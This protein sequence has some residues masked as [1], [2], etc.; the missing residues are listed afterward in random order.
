MAGK[1][2]PKPKKVDPATYARFKRE[3]R[4]FDMDHDRRIEDLAGGLE[5]KIKLIATLEEAL[6]NL[7]V[8]MAGMIK[9]ETADEM[10]ASARITAHREGENEAETRLRKE[11]CCFNGFHKF[12]EDKTMMNLSLVQVM[13]L[14]VDLGKRPMADYTDKITVMVPGGYEPRGSLS[15]LELDKAVDSA[16]N[17][18]FRSKRPFIQ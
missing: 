2:K 11:K 9:S 5:D 6:S 15:R 14:F 17:T 16:I 4:C 3:K 8:E 10:V 1:L 18:V 12:M 7:K 13:H